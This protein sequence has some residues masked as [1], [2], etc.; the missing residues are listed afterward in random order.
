LTGKVVARGYLGMPGHQAFPEP[1]TFRTDD[2]GVLTDAGLTVLG[3]A[4]EM[5]VSGGEKVPPA[6]I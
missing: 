5:I 6:P 1:G 3:R 2:L 4:D